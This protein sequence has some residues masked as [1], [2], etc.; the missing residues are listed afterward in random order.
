MNTYKWLG[1]EAEVSDFADGIMENMHFNKGGTG[2]F[3]YIRRGSRLWIGWFFFTFFL[4]FL[5]SACF[6]HG[7][8]DAFV[9]ENSILRLS[10]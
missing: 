1:D 9:N 6:D 3:F 8:K 5:P 7:I 2:L 4:R 10:I